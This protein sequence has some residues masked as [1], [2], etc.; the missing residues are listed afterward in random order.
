VY[1]EKLYIET[2]TRCNLKCSKCVKYAKGS[3]I[4]E[5][6][7]D[8]ATFTAL[9]VAFKNCNSVILNGIGEPLL[10]PHLPEMIRFVKNTMPREGKIGFQSNGVLLTPDFASE[11][12]QS[13]LDTI[14][15]SVDGFSTSPF[16]HEHSFQ[17]VTG[18]VSILNNLRHKTVKS[19]DVGIE[20]VLKRKSLQEL[21]GLINWAAESGVD[22]ILA[23]HLISYDAE[24]EQET[25]FHPCS[26][27][28]IQLVE[29]YIAIAENEG[30][31]LIDSYPQ[32]KQF[33][34]TRTPPHVL[35]I[36]TD[37]LKEAKQDGI[38][39]HLQTLF[40]RDRQD[41]LKIH[42]AMNEAHRLADE[43]GVTLTLPPLQSLN[44]D[45]RSCPFIEDKALFIGADGDIF[46]CHFLWHSYSCRLNKDTIEVQKRSLGNIKKDDI[47][48]IWQS[49]ESVTFRN[50]AKSATYSPCWNCALAP[51]PTLVNDNFS[52]MNDYFDSTVPC[53]HCHWNSGGFH[54]L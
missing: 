35:K 17:V 18:A 22:Y 42:K 8:M 10:H 53:G 51:C 33:M 36:Y 34:G 24:Q 19:F 44:L 16:E 43:K 21:P 52:L 14:C 32:Y 13:G 28:A 45:D 26:Q 7:I 6:E 9:S 38:Q 3:D 47:S 37:M 48:E 30:I 25:L 49:Q 54:C 27:N 41:D 31:D 50:E 5:G 1:P 2:T 29:K 23:T 40:D 39:L 4:R 15:F 20:I 12:L 46:P 11:L